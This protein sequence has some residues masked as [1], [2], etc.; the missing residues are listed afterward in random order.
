MS[1][2]AGMQ[3]LIIERRPCSAF[4]LARGLGAVIGPTI[5][6]AL[7]REAPTGHRQWGSA[8]SPGL[9]AL[10][11]GSMACSA[12]VG[13]LFAYSDAIRSMVQQFAL[14]SGRTSSTE[15]VSSIEMTEMTAKE[16][17]ALKDRDAV[18]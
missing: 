10:V 3:A 1:S 15:P 18:I 17:E 11:A 9:V 8:G 7:Y 13:V 14:R 12:A 6:A 5:G 2:T 16:D 4:S